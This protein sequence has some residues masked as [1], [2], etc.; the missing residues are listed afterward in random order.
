MSAVIEPTTRFAIGADRASYLLTIVVSAGS[1]ATFVRVTMTLLAVAET[2]SFVWWSMRRSM[3]V[4]RRPNDAAL[5]VRMPLKRQTYGWW[6]CALTTTST[7]GSSA[8]TIGLM[9]PVKLSQ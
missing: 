5:V 1:L 7:C 3:S 6:V 8:S 4:I 2:T 9:S